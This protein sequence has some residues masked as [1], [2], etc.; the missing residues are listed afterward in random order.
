MK[1]FLIA[2]Y[3]VLIEQLL[4]QVIQDEDFSLV[5]INLEVL[6]GFF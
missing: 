6:A 2:P 3:L 1:T 5:R 4:R